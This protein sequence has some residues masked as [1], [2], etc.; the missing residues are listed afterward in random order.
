MKLSYP[1]DIG[2]YKSKSSVL[3]LNDCLNLYPSNPQSTGAASRGGLYSMP[4]T[5]VEPFANTLGYQ[6]QIVFQDELYALSD[7]Q[8]LKIEEDGT[9]VVLGSL[10]AGAHQ[11]AGILAH[12]GQ[13][14]CI[15]I[16]GKNESYFYDKTNGLVRIVDPVFQERESDKGGIGGVT[17]IR[18][19]FA[20]T[21]EEYLFI[22]TVVTTNLGQTFL[23]L[24]K[25]RPFLQD[26][27]LRP[28]TIKGELYVFGE[29]SIKPYSYQGGP[30]FPLVEVPGGT[31]DKGLV[32]RFA[33]VAFDNTFTFLGGGVN[34]RVSVWRGTG[35]G[36]VTKISTDFIDDEWYDYKPLTVEG[37]F[38]GNCIT[39]GYMFEGRPFIGFAPFG[40]RAYLYDLVTS[41]TQQRHVWIQV[42]DG[43]L[44]SVSRSFG[45]GIIEAYQKLFY[46]TFGLM[47]EFT[48]DLTKIQNS[49]P[50][51]ERNMVFSGS[52]L[53]AQSDPLIINRIELIAETGVGAD[54]ELRIEDSNPMVRLHS[55]IDG[56]RTFRDHG[57]QALGRMGEYNKRLVWQRL[58]Y[59]PTSVIFKF[60]TSANVPVRF[61]RIDIEAQKGYRNA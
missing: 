21:T 32:D 3:A 15:V 6:G 1:V 44:D 48:P 22:S 27:A 20:F 60:T 30:D 42:S 46:V 26:K 58:N 49:N 23:A 36:T 55:S 40:K 28:M 35:G 9:E 11:S 4:G 7:T 52:Y 41:S 51:P 13:T 56:G 61:V 47:T 18:G 16:P 29:D 8:F 38:D 34:E 43:G 37:A 5:I 2:A 45:Y 19:H 31:I 50:I 59:M 33:V 39:F 24:D 53:Q 57:E 10:E 17:F 25:V 12:N 54:R 14:I